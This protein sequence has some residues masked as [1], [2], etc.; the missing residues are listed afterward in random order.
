[1]NGSRFSI[2]AAICPFRIWVSSIIVLISDRFVS[3]L[4][5]MRA[6]LA[7]HGSDLF[8]ENLIMPISEFQIVQRIDGNIPFL[9]H[10]MKKP[11]SSETLCG[12]RVDSDIW[13]KQSTKIP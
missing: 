8:G 4:T 2:R 6:K 9:V 11:D 12:I 10:L 7:L 1:M 5:T 13:H 3:G